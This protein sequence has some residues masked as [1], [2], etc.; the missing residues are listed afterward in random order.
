MK[1][2]VFGLLTLLL[3]LFSGLFFFLLLVLGM[4]WWASLLQAGLMVSLVAYFV[5]RDVQA[6]YLEMRES[7]W[8]EEE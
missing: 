8:K 5:F 3:A 4:V 7:K 6:P 2:Y 1:L